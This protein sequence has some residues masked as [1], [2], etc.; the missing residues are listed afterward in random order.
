MIGK[1]MQRKTG[2][3]MDFQ[4]NALSLYNPSN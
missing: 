1:I 2:V 3:N 4:S